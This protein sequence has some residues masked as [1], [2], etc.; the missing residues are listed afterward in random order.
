MWGENGPAVS[1]N[2]DEAAAGVNDDLTVSMAIM[3]HS[4][5][6]VIVNIMCTI[7]MGGG[8]LSPHF[9]WQPKNVKDSWKL[10]F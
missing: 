3:S 5:A 9:W 8:G 1:G 4:H 10:P 7:G 6:I 2:E